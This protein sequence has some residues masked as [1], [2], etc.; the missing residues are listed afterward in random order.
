MRQ[1]TGTDQVYSIDWDFP[2]TCT[3]LGFSTLLFLKREATF[4]GV[5]GE[6]HRGQGLHRACSICG[7]QR[8][9]KPILHHIK[10]KASGRQT[11]FK[12]GTGEC[13]LQLK[14]GLASETRE[15][16]NCN[17]F[18]EWK[19]V[20][21]PVTH[22]QQW[23]SNK[24]HSTLQRYLEKRS[25]DSSKYTSPFKEGANTF[26]SCTNMYKPGDIPWPRKFKPEVL[27]RFLHSTVSSFLRHS[28]NSPLDEQLGGISQPHPTATHNCA[29]SQVTEWG[30]HNLDIQVDYKSAENSILLA[31]YL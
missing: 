19:Q 20:P 17:P 11:Y 9:R 26:P 1:L 6:F 8:E 28:W 16:S 2:H 30:C 24:I 23:K 29:F 7:F 27:I 10:M 15:K 18:P 14:T 13:S 31:S 5:T 22:E 3:L 4:W 12:K 21:T 25:Y